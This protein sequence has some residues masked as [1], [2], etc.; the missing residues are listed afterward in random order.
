MHNRIDQELEKKGL[1]AFLV[2]DLVNIKYLTGFD[3]TYGF[4]LIL[5]R[6]KYFFTDSRYYERACRDLSGVNVHLIKNKWPELL[7]K[8]GVKKLGFEE[9]SVSFG[10]YKEWKKKLKGIKLIPVRN[11]V[12][13]IRQIKTANE[14]RIIKNAI[15]ITEH[16][17][18]KIQLTTGITEVE[19]AGR[20]E[21][22][23]RDIPGVRPSFPAIVSFGSNSSVPHAKPG[24][25]RLA[26]KNMILIDLGVRYNRYS[27]DL[28][29]TFW[30]GKIT[31]KF[32]QIYNIV[33][34]AQ[35]LA[36]EG[37][38]AGKKICE[39]DAL[40]RNHIKESGYG[41]YFGHALGHGIGLNIHEKPEINTKN[42]ERLQEGMVFTVE[43]GIY[44]PGWGG[45]RIEDMVLVTKNGCEV[46]TKSPKE[47]EDIVL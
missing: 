13:K 22:L 32:K 30:M 11:L 43:P 6:K 23:I 5:N 7:K 12:E 4:L 36:T 34:N 1:T 41:R 27:S 38:K 46:L 24:N 37:I 15:K 28:T 33:L 35:R 16:I 47:L 44:I 45:I 39:I 18:S 42:K 2:S 9:N 40:A 17:I 29:R 14:A 19:L 26:E 25:K 8:Y 31:Q 3:G 10:T 21:D 20:I